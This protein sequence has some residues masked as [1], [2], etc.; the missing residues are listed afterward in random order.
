MLGAA[1]RPSVHTILGLLE[2]AVSRTSCCFELLSYCKDS[3]NKNNTYFTR[4]LDVRENILGRRHA[5]FVHN[6]PG[7]TDHVTCPRVSCLVETK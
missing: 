5:V 3:S 7:Y 1:F 4:L 6:F 2:F